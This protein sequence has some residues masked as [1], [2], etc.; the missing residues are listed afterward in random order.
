[1]IDTSLSVYSFVFSFRRLF[2]GDGG[3]STDGG[4]LKKPRLRWETREPILFSLY[5]MWKN[6]CT[7]DRIKSNKENNRAFIRTEHSVDWWVVCFWSIGGRSDGG[8]HY[9][10]MTKKWP[11]AHEA[12]YC[13]K[14]HHH[15]SSQLVMVFLFGSS[16][17]QYVVKQSSIGPCQFCSS[18]RVDLIEKQ[19]RFWLWY[20][21]PTPQ[22]TQRMMRC[23]SCR[24]CIKAEYYYSTN[25]C[26][27]NGEKMK[28]SVV[29]GTPV[30]SREDVLNMLRSQLWQAARR[31]NRSAKL[32]S[33]ERK[34]SIQR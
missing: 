32:S 3:A 24:K 18:L 22:V 7:A 27:V 16:E 26:K 11:S 13:A 34:G 23:K 28:K 8:G 15:R 4:W 21:I 30:S 10:V 25:H 19:S 33:L 17:R 9:G 12:S 1:M 31:L 2:G 20:C 29:V 5:M 14:H 6:E